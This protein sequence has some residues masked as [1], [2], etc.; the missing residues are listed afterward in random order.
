MPME[1]SASQ[2]IHTSSIFKASNKLP[3]MKIK[4]RAKKSKRRKPSAEF[5]IV[6]SVSQ[7]DDHL[8]RR[9]KKA[10]GKETKNNSDIAI[11]Q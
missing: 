5:K 4:K 6:S 3:L 11:N 9:F 1:H 2:L 8:I 10:I 7:I